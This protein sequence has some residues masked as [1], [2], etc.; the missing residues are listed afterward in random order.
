M[1]YRQGVDH[2]GKDGPRKYPSG[3]RPRAPLVLL[4]DDLDDNRDMY[5]EM[6]RRAGYRVVEAENG[7][8]ALRQAR[9]ERPAIVVMDLSMPVMDGWEAMRKLRADP[10]TNG[11]PT[12]ALTGVGLTGHAEAM[13]S[14]CVAFLVKPCAPQDLVGVVDMTLNAA[15]AVEA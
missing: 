10:R 2:P 8:E 1:K 5:A 9:A 14:G 13:S 15:E 4:V 3:T 12:I 11:I 6:L 7:V